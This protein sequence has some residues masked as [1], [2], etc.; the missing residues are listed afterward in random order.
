[1]SRTK[2]GTATGTLSVRDSDVTSPQTV[3]LAGT[4]TAIEFSPSSLNVG[5]VQLGPPA[6]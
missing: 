2:I 4:G 6:R 1:M 5:S 3:A